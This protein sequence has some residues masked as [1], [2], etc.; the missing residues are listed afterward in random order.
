MQ[1]SP[2]APCGI[3]CWILWTELSIFEPEELSHYRSLR[4][5]DEKRFQAMAILAL[6]L[7]AFPIAVDPMGSGLFVWD[8]LPV[9]DLPEQLRLLSP[10]L[11]GVGLGIAVYRKKQTRLALGVSGLALTLL[12]LLVFSKSQLGYQEL[13]SG[14]LDFV[15]RQ[16]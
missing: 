9:S 1:G 3:N 16:P 14:V 8:L 4:I 10:A 5:S 7:A 12:F 15:G 13:F 2:D 11:L 6:V